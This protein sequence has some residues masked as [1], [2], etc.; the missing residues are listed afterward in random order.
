MS[1]WDGVKH[2]CCGGDG[3]ETHL[4]RRRLDRDCGRNGNIVGCGIGCT[5]CT[6]IV[7]HANFRVSSCYTVYRPREL[8]IADS[9][10]G[11][12]ELLCA[13]CTD[14]RR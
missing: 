1:I 14:A 13:A 12:G 8:R 4:M 10:H 5:E 3:S 7:D 6:G 2:I 11:R 9:R